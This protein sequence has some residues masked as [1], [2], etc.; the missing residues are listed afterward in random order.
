MFSNSDMYKCVVALYLS[1]SCLDEAKPLIGSS[2]A[3]PFLIQVLRDHNIERSSCKYDALYILYNLSTHPPNI[4]SLVSSDII[5]SLHPFFGFP[6]AS[7]VVMLAEK[8]LAIL[9]NLAASR[10]GRKE[11]TSAPSIFRGLA[12]VLDFGESTEQEQAVSCLLI[13]CSGDERCSQMVLQEGVI[14]SLVSISVNGTTKGK[15]KTEK[16]LKLFR[17]Q[18]QQEP[19]TLKQQPQQVEK[20]GGC[21]M[22]VE[23]KTLSSIWKN[24]SFSV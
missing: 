1:L 15:E 21:E 18:R 13:L 12:G 2:M 7:E 19:S 20:N 14:P 8:A 4:P 23:W 16:L 9:I 11:I 17:E 22:I 3:V 10:A 5:N 24:K 6:S